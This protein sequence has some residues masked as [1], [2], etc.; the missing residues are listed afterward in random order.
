MKFSELTKFF[1]KRSLFWQFTAI[2]SMISLFAL[3]F[4][5]Y[6]FLLTGEST[7]KGSA[8]NVSGSLRMQTYVTALTVAQSIEQSPEERELKITAAL[9]EFQRRLLSPGLTN[10]IP[11]NKEDPLRQSYDKI[12][13]SF[14]ASLK[15]LA[16]AVI[17]DAHNASQFFNYVPVFVSNIDRFVFELE[18]ELERKMQWVKLGLIVT[19]IITLLI[20]A[21]LLF[22]FQKVFFSPLGHLAEVASEVRRGNF[23]ARSS[24]KKTNEI[25][26]LSESFNFMI[27]DL[28]RLY[29]SLEDQ[30]RE[31]TADLDE[32]NKILNLLFGLRSVFGQTLE[33]NQEQLEIGINL[34][35]QYLNASSA[36]LALKRSREEGIHLAAISPK[37]SEHPIKDVKWCLNFFSSSFDKK[38]E[39]FVTGSSSPSWIM[40]PI[41]NRKVS[42]GGLFINL[43]KKEVPQDLYNQ[44]LF[45]NIGEIFATALDNASKKEEGYR[46]A[47][48]EERST[49]ARELHD[50]IAQSL[51][52]SRIQL[53]RLTVAIEKKLPEDQVFE[54]VN[55]LKTGVA[56][57]YSQ[58]REVL[59]TFRLKPASTDLRDS[60]RNMLDTF[61]ERSGIAYTYTNSLFGF[62]IGANKQIH[63]L[64]LISEAL[65]NTEKHSHATQVQVEIKHLG[66]NRLR[67]SVIDNGVGVEGGVK[68][69]VGH[70][71]LSIMNERARILGGEILITDTIPHGVT[72]RLDFDADQ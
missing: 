32:R 29:K 2:L 58:L 20:G 44:Q 39:P 31:K 51:A 6:F 13:S 54:I 57:A 40:V 47:V 5:F 28:S 38:E 70:F 63:L 67:L 4:V 27:D 60:L 53:T 17:S 34:V 21:L 52:Y 19:M 8:I 3:F 1:S 24:Y 69:R 11:E 72:V 23:S 41:K 49:I 12:Y 71:G 50:S 33:I 55:D 65:S 10:G 30:V 42:F 64:Q 15:P 26:S 37:S 46:L 7:G 48:L 45:K 25:G 68:E 43:G 16:L 35:R 61:H 59:T 66:G 56:T 18:E 14:Y 9:N 36:V 62:E 22:Y